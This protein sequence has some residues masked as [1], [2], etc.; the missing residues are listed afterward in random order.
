[1]LISDSVRLTPL[2]DAWV[3]WP[4]RKLCPE[5]FPVASPDLAAARFNSLPIESGCRRDF[6]TLPCRSTPRK[7]APS[8]IPDFLSH[9]SSLRTGHVSESLPL[10]IAIFRPAASWSVFDRDRSM[11]TPSGHRSMFSTLIEESSERRNAPLKPTSSNARS[12]APSRLLGQSET[13]GS[14]K[15]R[16]AFESK[17]WQIRPDLVCPSMILTPC[18]AC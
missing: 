15:L 18:C 7:T 6:E 11:V 16:S 12:R 1:M 17:S 5:I 14:P 2:R 10:G 4:T 3:T 9:A 13:C 8:E